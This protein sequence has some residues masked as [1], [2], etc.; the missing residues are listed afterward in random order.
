MK[1]GLFNHVIFKS[2][3]KYFEFSEGEGEDTSRTAVSLRHQQGSPLLQQNAAECI[4]HQVMSNRQG[5]RT[6]DKS[7]I[8]R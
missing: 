4:C 2:E 1:G 3:T 8:T 7:H 5:L 6:A